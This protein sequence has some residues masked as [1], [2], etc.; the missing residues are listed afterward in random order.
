[1]E[2]RHYK[3]SR[4]IIAQTLLTSMLIMTL[5]VTNAM[6]QDEKLGITTGDRQVTLSWDGGQ[7]DS[8]VITGTRSIASGELTSPLLI[9]G[10]TNGQ[11]YTFEI[12]FHPIEWPLVDVGVLYAIPG[13][14]TAPRN[15]TATA[16]HGKVTLNWQ[17]PTTDSSTFSYQLITEAGE[18]KDLGEN[19]TTCTISGLPNG[20]AYTCR[21]VASRAFSDFPG[22][23][24]ESWKK[25]LISGSTPLITATP[26]SPPTTVAITAHAGIISLNTP[27]SADVEVRTINGQTILKRKV[28]AGTSTIPVPKGL[29]LVSLGEQTVKVAVN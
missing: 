17:P 8:I 5:T 6:A 25:A 28:T 3:Y 1:M 26:Q 16:G 29:Y 24:K 9:D 20:E 12:Y 14:P 19:I 7:A 2:K 4:H 22:K 11:L 15:L 21:I 23:E 13:E 18:R 27:D 10:L